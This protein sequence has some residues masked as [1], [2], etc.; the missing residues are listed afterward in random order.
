MSDKML[1]SES[2]FSKSAAPNRSKILEWPTIEPH[3]N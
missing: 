2:G 1:G 3:Y